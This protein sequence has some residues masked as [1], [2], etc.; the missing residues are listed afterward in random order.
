[1]IGLHDS[2]SVTDTYELIYNPLKAGKFTGKIFFSNLKTGQFWY[3]LNLVAKTVSVSTV[4]KHL[5]CMLG[6]DLKFS[7][8]VENT[9]GNS[10]FH[11][12]NLS[13]LV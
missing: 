8:P 2:N 5:E 4:L 10:L 1:M 6:T 3:N 9:S 7:I 12:L 11:D 13:C